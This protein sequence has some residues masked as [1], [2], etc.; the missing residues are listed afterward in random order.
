[1]DQKRILEELDPFFHPKSLA[2]IGATGKEGKV[3]RLFMDRFLEAGFQKLYPVNPR[4]NE[5]LGMK[6]F[7]TVSE[8]PDKVD[9]ALILTPPKAVLD[10]VKD[11]VRK[12]VKGIIITTAGFREA[13]EEGLQLQKEVVRIAQEGGARIL[14]PNCIGIYCPSA[15]LPFPQRPSMESGSVGVISQSGSTADYITMIATKNGVKFSKAISCG[16][17]GDLTAVDF[18]NYL[19]EDPETNIIVSYLEEIKDGRQ[20]FQSVKGISKRKPILLWKGG[21]T[22]AGARAAASHTGALAGSQPIWNGALRQLGIIGVKSFE[23]VMDCLYTFYYL[24]L[25]LGRRVAIVTGVGG[26]AVSAVDACL[27]QGLEVPQLSIDTKEELKKVV[28]PFGTSVENPI[29]IGIAALV[30]PEVYG[31]VIKVLGRDKNIDM[32]IMIGEGGEPMGSI[33]AKAGS[34]IAK[35]VVMAVINT[36][37]SV[38]QDYKSL[39]KKGIPVYPDPSRAANALAKLADYAEYRR[40]LPFSNP[41]VRNS[42]HEQ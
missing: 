2:L 22:E 23:E 29:D 4:E 30:T 18:F 35:P 20:F 33:V 25:P 9:L 12:G 17:E 40:G 14:G 38:A 13:G 11:C 8:I 1:M 24:E 19:G 31:N 21:T 26:P 37:E 15:R 3:G 28:P 5:I 32:V 34:D 7:P 36:L 42:R 16:N 10:A 6:A 41:M 27:E 39:L